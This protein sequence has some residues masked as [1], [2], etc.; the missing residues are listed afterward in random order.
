M[1]FFKALVLIVRLALEFADFA[2]QQHSFDKG[3]KE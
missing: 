2:R 1:S 3:N